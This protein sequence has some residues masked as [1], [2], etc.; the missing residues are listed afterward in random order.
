M[1]ANFPAKSFTIKISRAAVVHLNFRAGSTFPVP[2]CTVPSSMDST[3][4]CNKVDAV[5]L[6]ASFRLNLLLL[7]GQRCVMYSI[8]TLPCWRA[9]ENKYNRI[10]LLFLIL[11]VKPKLEELRGHKVRFI[12]ISHQLYLPLLFCLQWLKTMFI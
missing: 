3:S 5:R 12:L 9:I 11:H 7:K 4:P 1:S 10:N 6:Y 8:K 2:V